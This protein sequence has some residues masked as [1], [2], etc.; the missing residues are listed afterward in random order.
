MGMLVGYIPRDKAALLSPAMQAHC[1]GIIETRGLI[2]GGWKDGSSEGSY[3][4]RVWLSSS[5]AKRLNI[6]PRDIE[7]RHEVFEPSIQ[8]PKLPEP[9]EGE[10]RLTPCADDYIALPTTVTVT[11]E[12]HYQ[13]AIA[14]T[15]PPG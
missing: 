6:D 15:R 2:V 10:R 13:I 1:G 3:G 12:E 8:Y 4:I 5:D 7:L 9:T 11:Q 14:A